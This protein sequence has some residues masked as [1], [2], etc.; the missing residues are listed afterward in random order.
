[1]AKLPRLHL[2]KTCLAAQIVPSLNGRVN[3]WLSRLLDTSGILTQPK[4][5]FDVAWGRTAA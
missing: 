2:L 4:L 3:P 5:L 1:L